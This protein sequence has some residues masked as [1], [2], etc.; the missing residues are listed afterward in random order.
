MTEM[1]III[2][3]SINISPMLLMAVC[4]V[5]SNHTNVINVKDGNSA[6]Y[7]ICQVK[8][9]TAK[10]L[11]KNITITDLMKPE[12]NIRISAM[13]LKKQ[14]NRYNCVDSAIAAYN[15]GRVKYNKRGDLVNRRYVSKV[16]LHLKTKPWA[17][18]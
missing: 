18:K 16:K 17:K 14:L 12:V 2:A 4:S 5:E 1:F 15:A 6:S 11:D 13:Y 9:S 8:Y 3:K 7:G 10:M